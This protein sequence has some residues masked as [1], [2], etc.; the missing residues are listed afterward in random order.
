MT[1]ILASASPVADRAGRREW[2]GLGVIALPCMLYAMDLTVLN[3][4]IPRLSAAL[5]PSS[6]QL[7]WIADI[8]GFVLAGLLIP[9]GMLGDRIGR[10]KLLLIGAAAFGVASIGA[11][12]ASSAGALIVARAVLGV[13]G[14]T[15]AP[16]TLSLIRNMFLDADQ[17]TKAIGVWVMSYSVGGSLG[18]IVGGLLLERFWWGSVFLIGVPVMLL[19]LVVGP[20]LLPEFRDPA[21][22]RIDVAS[23]GLSL[24]A[25]L[26][27]IYGVKQLVVSSTPGVALAT[28][29]A[30]LICGAVFV[31]R[32][33]TLRDPIVD[34]ELLRHRPFA[35]SLAAYT[36]ATFLSFGIYLFIGQYL[37]LVKGLSSLDAAVAS[38]PMFAG[39]AIGSFASPV[40][41]RRF[42]PTT[43]MA[44]GL[45]TSAIGFGV[46][47][48]MGP[49]TGIY[50]TLAAIVMYSIGLSPVVTLSMDLILGSAPPERAGAAS[51]LAETGSE[52]GGALGIALLGSVGAVVYR[53]S[54]SAA[55]PAAVS[56]DLAT[57]ARNT[58]G[59]AIA[60]AAQLSTT[61]SNLLTTAARS[62]FSHSMNVVAWV[63][64]AITIA[65]AA[66]V[67]HARN[68]PTPR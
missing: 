52:L 34:L 58:L 2:I 53:S 39:F 3:L 32:Q 19:L 13:A 4:A 10:R 6:T 37:Q 14:A 27:V 42:A 22:A 60:A 63:C 36:L 44:S 65:M 56:I 15:L 48:V 26:L 59:G 64:L 12:F 46:F 35:V 62:A 25:V 43:V 28:I 29:V 9:M 11:A 30:G 5:H 7:L 23:A 47:G 66:A 38:L 50:T 49:S 40:L 16:S 57:N 41:A 33:R 55:M 24:V 18:P 67:L 45:I 21:S 1:A 31:R 8:Y 20:S 17:R 51:A 54:M 68:E 61:S